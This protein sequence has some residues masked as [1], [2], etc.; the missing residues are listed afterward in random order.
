MNEET[1][2][3]ISTAFY[4]TKDKEK[5]TGLGVYISKCIIQEME[6]Q[7]QYESVENQGTKVTITLPCEVMTAKE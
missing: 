3:K 2:N 6:G 4:T 1:L 5:G 7:L